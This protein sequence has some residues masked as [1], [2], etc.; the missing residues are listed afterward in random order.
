M[1]TAAWGFLLEAVVQYFLR[2]LLHIHKLQIGDSMAYNDY[3][4]S[5][6]IK[7]PHLLC[8]CEI[9]ARYSRTELE[10]HIYR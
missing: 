2:M 8:I 7:S 6:H 9:S 10:L 1:I 4:E 5:Y 3:L